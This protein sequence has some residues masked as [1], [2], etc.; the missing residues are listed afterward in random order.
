MSDFNFNVAEIKFAPP[1]PVYLIEYVAKVSNPEGQDKEWERGRLLKYLVNNQ[2]WSPLEMVNMLM[3]IETTR[4]IARQLLRHRSF[5]FQEFSQRYAAVKSTLVFK[6][7]R[8]QDSKNRQNSIDD[9]DEKIKNEWNDIQIRVE[10]EASNSYDRAI[11]IGIAKEV[12]RVI[13]PEGM[14]PSRLYVNGSVR[15]WYHYC[16]LRMENGTQLEHKDLATKCNNAL[17]SIMPEL[18]TFGEVK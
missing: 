15:S 9:L 8:R 10:R 16:Q 12:A 1:D 4:D 13:L 5:T 18:F 11:K 14:T 3:Y 2:H 7:A 6:E 17:S